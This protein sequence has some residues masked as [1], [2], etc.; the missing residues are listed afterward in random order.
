MHPVNWDECG[1]GPFGAVSG[2]TTKPGTPAIDA[3]SRGSAIS[4][5]KG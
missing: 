2:R 4:R 1:N 5:A 3:A